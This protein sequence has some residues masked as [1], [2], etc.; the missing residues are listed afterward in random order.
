MLVLTHLDKL[1]HEGDGNV[2]QSYHGMK[3]WWV[4]TISAKHFGNVITWARD[5]IFLQT[6]SVICYQADSPTYVLFI[7]F[8]HCHHLIS[9]PMSLN[10]RNL[11]WKMTGLQWP[12]IPGELGGQPLPLL[13]LLLQPAHLPPWALPLRWPVHECHRCLR[14]SRGDHREDLVRF[15]GGRVL[16]APTSPPSLPRLWLLPR[17]CVFHS[18]PPLLLQGHHCDLGVLQILGQ[19]LLLRR[20]CRSREAFWRLP[21]LFPPGERDFTF[22]FSAIFTKEKEINGF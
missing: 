8:Y 20:Y 22:D 2:T 15:E 14:R 21:L 7:G 18:Y 9:L 11:T 1:G 4:K 17:P 19:S 12:P 10:Q 5:M 16:R 13:L 6:K 3:V